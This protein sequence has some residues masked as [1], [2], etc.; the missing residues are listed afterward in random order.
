LTSILL[1]FVLL[2][3]VIDIY[4]LYLLQLYMYTV[5]YYLFFNTL[6]LTFMSSSVLFNP[7]AIVFLAIYYEVNSSF[8]TKLESNVH[9]F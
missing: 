9:F 4:L 8:I 7:V 5:F 1:N 2:I 6:V 3:D